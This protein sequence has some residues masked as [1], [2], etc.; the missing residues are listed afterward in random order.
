MVEEEDEAEIDREVDK[1]AIRLLY[2]Q[3]NAKRTEAAPKWT[4]G[5]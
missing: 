4:S 3:R 2:W 5:K 1:T